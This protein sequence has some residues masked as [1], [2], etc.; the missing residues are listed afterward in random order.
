MRDGSCARKPKRSASGEA[1]IDASSSSRARPRRTPAAQ[2]HLDGEALVGVEADLVGQLREL[3]GLRGRPEDE[4]RGRGCARSGT[5]T[6]VPATEVP[7]A[8]EAAR[9]RHRDEARRCESRP[10]VYV[11]GSASAARRTLRSA[12]ARKPMGRPVVVHDAQAE[13]RLA[14]RP[15][16]PGLEHGEVHP[17]DGE[18]DDQQDADAGPRSRS[19]PRRSL[20]PCRS[21]RA[22]R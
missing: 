22:P 8:L 11:S 1:I 2:E 15:P 6:I 21:R 12:A 7:E 20:P 16:A 13:G 18:E 17:L 3:V 10:A 9:R 5:M 19:R 4:R 14:R